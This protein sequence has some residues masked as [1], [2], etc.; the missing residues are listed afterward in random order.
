M[1][2]TNPPTDSLYKFVALTGMAITIASGTAAYTNFRDSRE[3]TFRARENLEVLKAE[4]AHY[5][6]VVDDVGGREDS[7]WD[8]KKGKDWTTLSDSDKSYVM[9]N[10]K[11]LDDRHQRLLDARLQIDRSTAKIDV[12][13]R[14]IESLTAE[15]ES[16]RKFYGAFM[17]FGC[18]IT[19][20]GFYFWY[21]RLQKYLDRKARLD[22]DAAQLNATEA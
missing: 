19:G 4:I 9:E 15:R 8:I 18:L 16:D 12:Q 20:L 11:R 22:A 5:D 2:V 3:R 17:A 13:V 6:S 1:F 14:E 7:L 21:S 10:L